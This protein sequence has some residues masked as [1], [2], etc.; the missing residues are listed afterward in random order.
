MG[1]VAAKRVKIRGVVG[2]PSTGGYADLRFT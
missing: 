1:S 2:H